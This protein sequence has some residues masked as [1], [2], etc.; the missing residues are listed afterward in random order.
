MALRCLIY[1][2]GYPGQHELEGD[3]HLH[4]PPLLGQVYQPVSPVGSHDVFN[5]GVSRHPRSQGWSVLRFRVSRSRTVV[6]KLQ[7]QRLA[8]PLRLLRAL[9]PLSKRNFF[10]VISCAVK[11]CAPLRTARTSFLVSRSSLSNALFG[12]RR[13]DVYPV[14]GIS[15][16]PPSRYALGADAHEMDLGPIPFK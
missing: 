3:Q 9:T 16:A 2:G 7:T 14:S 4:H 12:E 15:V 13:C 5:T 6:R 10:E 1:A 11:G 8:K